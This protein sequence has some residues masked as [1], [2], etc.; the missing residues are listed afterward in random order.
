MVRWKEEGRLGQVP[1]NNLT[2]P[3]SDSFSKGTYV[4]TEKKQ[5]ESS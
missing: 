2:R 4:L 3:M 5:A 1:N